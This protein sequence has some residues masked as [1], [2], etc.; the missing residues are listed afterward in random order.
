[1]ST[2]AVLEQA[3]RHDVSPTHTARYDATWDGRAFEVSEDGAL[4][5]RQPYPIDVLMV[6]EA[7]IYARALAPFAQTPAALVRAACIRVDGGRLLLVGDHDARRT[8]L[9][10]AL[11]RDGAAVEGDWT[12]VVDGPSVRTVARPLRVQEE[13]LESLPSAAGLVEGRSSR[14]PSDG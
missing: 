11:L 5:S 4:L 3:A 8:A 6:L 1:M 13:A 9:L 14:T 2:L 12:V 10:L 7:Q